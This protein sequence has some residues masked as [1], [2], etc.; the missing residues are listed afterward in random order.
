VLTLDTRISAKTTI[1]QPL[2][3][4][5]LLHQKKSHVAEFCFACRENKIHDA[6]QKSIRRFPSTQ[7]KVSKLP[8]ISKNHDYGQPFVAWRSEIIDLDGLL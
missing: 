6:A 7:M 5:E 1:Q 2:G 8:K 3:I 4:S